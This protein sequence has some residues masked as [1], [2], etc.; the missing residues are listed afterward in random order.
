MEITYEYELEEEDTAQSPGLDMHAMRLLEDL[1]EFGQDLGRKFHQ[2]DEAS[3]TSE[4]GFEWTPWH[5]SSED[6]RPCDLGFEHVHSE[7]WEYCFSRYL[8]C[9]FSN[10]G[11]AGILRRAEALSS[12]PGS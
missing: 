3:G 1:R 5:G 7:T 6:H 8:E 10:K 12:N 2:R 11:I 9:N 4:P